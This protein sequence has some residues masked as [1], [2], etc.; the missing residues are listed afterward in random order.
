VRPSGAAL[1]LGS[2][3]KALAAARSLSRRG[4]R[5]AVVD[6]DRRAAWYSRH[7][8]TRIYWHGSLDDP[9]LVDRLLMAAK[10][11]GLAGAVLFPMQDDA[12][13]LVSR[14]H[15]RLRATYR[16]TTAPWDLLRRAQEK[17]LAYQAADA[18]GVDHPVTWQPNDLGDMR[19]LPI[20]LPAIVKPSISTKLV[21]SIHRKALLA[22][23]LD[24]LA[25][26]YQL[27]LRYVPAS[28][29]LV[30]EFIPG[31]GENQYSFCA[32]VDGGRIRASM[33]ARRLRQYPIDFG[34]SSSLV[35]AVEV[36]ELLGPSE[37]LLSELGLSGLVE[38]EFKRHPDTGRFHLLDINVRAW[39][40]HSLCTECGV[41]FI[42]LQYRMAMGQPLPKVLPRYTVRWRRVLTDIPAGVA[43]IRAGTTT[44]GS[45]MRSLRGTTTYSVLDLR[46]PLPS[47]ADPA[48]AAIR[49]LRRSH[50]RP[51]ERVKEGGAVRPAPPLG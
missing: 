10:E 26:M 29:L 4:V 3:F 43:S 7:V 22:N 6:S 25:E 31:G 9:A 47:L 18:A 42:D 16:L 5:V 21:R 27:A 30:Q 8:Q 19:R 38:L 44:F 15:Q 28:G 45:Y 24:E 35:E 23:T 32:L 41:D 12:V 40:W 14:N 36:P 51:D 39:A 48:V 1:L 50:E 2:D 49:L 34:M 37:L 33:T 20:R 17:R 11:D 46:D 13:E